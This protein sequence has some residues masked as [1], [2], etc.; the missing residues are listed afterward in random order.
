MN[1]INQVLKF[2]N[3]GHP[4]SA[5]L[6]KN[7]TASLV[8]K[9]V[10]IVLGFI[11]VPI[12]IAY[13]APEKYG[14]W[15]TISSIILWVNYFDLGLGNGLRNKFAESRSL[16]DLGR[17]QKLVSTAYASITVLVM[18]IFVIGVP[19]IFLLDWNVILNVSSI[20]NQ[21]LQYSVAIV[22]FM[23]VLRLIFHLI[24]AILKADQR[25][26]ISDLFLPISSVV[27][28]V[29]I[30]LVRYFTE[31]SLFLASV[32]VSMPP[33]VI[34]FFANIY[35]FRKDYKQL[36]PSWRRVEKDF[37]KDIYSL[38]IKFFAIQMGALILFGSSNIILTQVLNPEAV[39]I[40][41]VAEKYFQ[42]PLMF[43]TIILTPFWSAITD[44]YTKQEFEWI[45][46]S[47]NR[48]FLISIIFTLGIFF[49]LLMS[50]FAFNIWLGGSVIIPIHLS[51][52][53]AIK[54]SL[55]LILS[56]Y[57]TFLAGVGKLSLDLRI[58]LFK[59][60]FYLPVAIFLS[61][62]MGVLG[63]ALALI[64]VNSLPNI[65][66]NITQYKLVINRKAYGIWNA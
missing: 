3:Q 4:R 47:M 34:L 15:L 16:N 49:M 1:I 13:L 29:L 50:N 38:G 59:T 20:E 33:T 46:N 42:L 26:A 27:S 23:F 53:L 25:P 30:I 24:T 57:S 40:Y 2:L 63:L 6:K 55:L 5:K 54:N 35:F 7:I 39:T 11:K 36:C 60:I 62:Q 43:Y 12:L 48:L 65:I 44:A 21:E 22:F 19:L 17:S 52:M 8:I 31:D 14:V 64:L 41:N 18:G 37:V 58:L 45:K 32:V 56:P 10:A 28:I 51:I 66:F 61:Q 9:A